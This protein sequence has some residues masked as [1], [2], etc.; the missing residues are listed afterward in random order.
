M[1]EAPEGKRWYGDWYGVMKEEWEQKDYEDEVC[2]ACPYSK[3]P[4]GNTYIKCELFNGCASRLHPNKASCLVIK[5]PWGGGMGSDYSKEKF[6]AKMREEHGDES[7][8]RFTI[9]REAII[10]RLLE[11]GKEQR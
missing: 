2:S 10:R 4:A 8:R 9:K 6:F 11:A 7:V 1:P 5:R 3:G